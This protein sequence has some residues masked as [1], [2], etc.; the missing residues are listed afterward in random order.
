M[1]VFLKISPAFYSL[2][3][4]VNVTF[5]TI[6]IDLNFSFP[7]EGPVPVFRG[8]VVIR[9]N[10]LILRRKDYFYFG[11]VPHISGKQLPELEIGH[12]E[13]ITHKN[14]FRSF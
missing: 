1:T 9:I 14:N 13:G 10:G 6:V 12:W 4:P 7:E 11:I 2:Y 8:V 3:E 5:Y